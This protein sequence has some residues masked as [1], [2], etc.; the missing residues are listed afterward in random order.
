MERM[1]DIIKRHP[2][3]FSP[4]A[5]RFFRSKTYPEVYAD[6]I[7][8]TSEQDGDKNP[9]RFSIRIESK[10]KA[11]IN[12]IGEFQEFRTLGSAK[13]MAKRYAENIDLLN[14]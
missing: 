6:R 10:D 12:T 2:K 11:D 1:E 4:G 5:M 7:F 14:H 13:K 3:Y 8:I 9:R